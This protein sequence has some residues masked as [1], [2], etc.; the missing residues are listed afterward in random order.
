M[1][2]AF[3]LVTT[4]A[5]KEREVFEDIGKVPGVKDVHPLFGEYDIIIKVEA[6]SHEDIGNVVVDF[7]RNIPGVLDTKT[8]MRINEQFGNK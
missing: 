4:A 7:I 5:G 6:A 2:I 1:V 3:V 8:L